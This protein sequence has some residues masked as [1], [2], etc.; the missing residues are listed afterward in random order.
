[1]EDLEILYRQGTEVG[2]LSIYPFLGAVYAT[3]RSYDKGVMGAGFY[4]LDENRGRCCQL[5]EERKETP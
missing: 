2:L 3:D 1:M 4:R 5:G